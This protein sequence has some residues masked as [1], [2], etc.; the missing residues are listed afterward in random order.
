MIEKLFERFNT[1]LCIGGAISVDRILRKQGINY[2]EA[3]NFQYKEQF[4]EGTIPNVVITHP[5]PNFCFPFTKD[6]N[7]DRIKN[8]YSLRRCNNI[9]LNAENNII[10]SIKNARLSFIQL[11]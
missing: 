11:S 1:T 3:E 6:S 8:F 4:L 2:W 5:S 7:T 10:N 9:I